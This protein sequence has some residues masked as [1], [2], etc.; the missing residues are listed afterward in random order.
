MGHLDQ[1]IQQLYKLTL[2]LGNDKLLP[3]SLME[4]ACENVNEGKC[5]ANVNVEAYIEV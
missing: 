4:G 1:A 3:L 5:E 2:F